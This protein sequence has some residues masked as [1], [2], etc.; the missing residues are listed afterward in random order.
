V[1]SLVVALAIMG[2][3]E[4]SATTRTDEAISRSRRWVVRSYGRCRGVLGRIVL[5]ERNVRRNLSG[6]G[7]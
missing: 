3:T 7:R 2:S 5:R 6:Y 1:L 4:R